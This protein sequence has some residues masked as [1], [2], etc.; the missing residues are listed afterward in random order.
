M[1]VSVTERT[2]EIGIRRALGATRRSVLWQ[3]LIEASVLSS[4]GGVI[5]VGLAFSFIALMQAIN[6]QAV[7]V[8][9]AVILG[10][11]FSSL[12]GLSAGFLPALK[13]AN[14]D[15]IDALRYE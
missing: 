14:L 11:G 3:F 5:G 12:I 13:A 10:M 4:L 9:W 2:R 6:V 1:L 7:I 15:V 8:G